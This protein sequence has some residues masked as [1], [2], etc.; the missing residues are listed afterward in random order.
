VKYSSALTKIWLSFQ[1]E[2]PVCEKQPVS[3][4][5]RKVIN[6]LERDI[7]R[8]S[9][10]GWLASCYCYKHCNVSVSNPIKTTP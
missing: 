6:G 8:Q 9:E 3:E 4:I 1:C 10:K 7:T 5:R 2:K